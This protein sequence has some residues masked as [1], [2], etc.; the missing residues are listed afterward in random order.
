[1]NRLLPYHLDN[2][3]VSLFRIRRGMRRG[4][5]GKEVGVDEGK[6]IRI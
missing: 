3:N 1:M 2:L 6:S 4:V 5:R